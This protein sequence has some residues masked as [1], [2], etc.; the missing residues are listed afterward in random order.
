M[1]VPSAAG[2][3]P[4]GDA[5]RQSIRRRQ[6]FGD[7]RRGRSVAPLR[8]QLAGAD[9]AVRIGAADRRQQETATTSRRCRRSPSSSAMR[10]SHRGHESMPEPAGEWRR[11]S[12]TARARAT[13]CASG[14]T[15]RQSRSRCRR[16]RLSDGERP[17]VAASSQSRS[18]IPRS[19]GLHE[20]QAVP[21]FFHRRPRRRGFVTKCLV[22]SPQAPGCSL[23]RHRSRGS[24]SCAAASACSSA[25]AARSA[26]S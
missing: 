2:V 16:G 9:V 4:S 19:G 6:P 26:I 23:R 17:A 1:P 14:P 24:R 15:R 10:V 22:A 5:M 3:H 11:G 8:E 21:I 13:R 7:R 12:P 18:R 20:S 25:R